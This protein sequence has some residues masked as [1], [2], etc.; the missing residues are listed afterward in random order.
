MLSQ[1]SDTTSVFV[2][3][4]MEDLEPAL[5][6]FVKTNV[7]SFIKW[8][9]LRLFHENRD[10]IDTAE[11]I[12]KYVGRTVGVIEQELEDL[13]ESGLMVK[14]GLDGGF[15]YSLVSDETTWASVSNFVSACEDR[16]IRIKVVYHIVHEIR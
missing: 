13:V 9:L 11:N 16:D 12:A 4:L 7:N 14:R 15:T 1:K 10:I 8:D 6:D 2:T 5:L 3:R